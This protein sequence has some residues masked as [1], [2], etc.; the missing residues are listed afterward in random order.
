MDIVSTSTRSRMMSGIRG[1]NTKPELAVRRYLHARGFRYR[2]SVRD[3]PGR[4]DVVLPKYRAVVQVHGCFWHGHVSCRFATRPATRPEFWAAKIDGNIERDHRS[5]AALRALGWRVAVV[6]ECALR[7]C[8]DASL[9]ALERFLR[10][11]DTEIE[12]GEAGIYP[13]LRNE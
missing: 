12:I 9:A 7:K 10:S 5:S 1:K 2:L 13:A 4:P 8:P 3:L 6:W 11:E